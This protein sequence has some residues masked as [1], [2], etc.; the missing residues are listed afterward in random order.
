MVIEDPPGI[1]LPFNSKVDV[2]I[3]V[4]TDIPLFL[5]EETI[6]REA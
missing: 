3:I 4:I 2:I 6:A 5:H 1:S